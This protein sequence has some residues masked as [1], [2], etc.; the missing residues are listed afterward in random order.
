MANGRF[1]RS[2]GGVAGG[3]Y[4]AVQ[5]RQLDGRQWLFEVL[6]GIGGGVLGGKL[7]DMID[8]PTSPRH[9]S[10]GHG[11]I[12]VTGMTKWVSKNLGAIQEKC[13]SAATSYETRARQETDQ[14]KAF[15]FNILAVLLRFLAGA[16]AGVVAGYLS[17]I[18]V[19]GFTPMSLPLI[20]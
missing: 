20:A 4:A 9:R 14:F 6:G 8:P 11:V 17:H 16:V 3:G 5:A 1:H 18:V 19:D 15:V 12:P 2:L 13:R 10:I 7:P